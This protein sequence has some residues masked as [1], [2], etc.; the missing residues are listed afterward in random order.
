[1]LKF[2]GKSV[3]I[4]LL[5]FVF[6][7]IF[8][9]IPILQNLEMLNPIENVFD[10]F[11]MTDIVFSQLREPPPVD[12]NIVMVNFGEIDREGLALMIER[13]NEAQPL[14]I[15]IDAFY[16]SPKPEYPEGDSLLAH[17]LSQVKNLVM[18]S[19]LGQYNEKKDYYDTLETSH[20]MFIQQGKSAFANLTTAGKGNME[21]FLTSR[22]F[23]PV[24]KVKNQKHYAFAVELART[25]KPKA[26]ERFLKR[27]KG[28]ELINYRGNIGVE[29]GEDAVFFALD[30]G[31]VLD[32][33]A[34]LSFI[35]D[36]IVIIG[37]MGKVLGV[38]SFDDKF[39][40]PLNKNYVGKSTP[41]MYGVVVHANIV[42]MILNENYISE[43]PTWANF[44]LMFFITYFSVIL[45]SYLFH[46]VGY[47][48]DA[49][50][51]ILQL[52]IFLLI[53]YAGLKSFQWYNLKIGINTAII[54]VIIAGI[55]IEIYYGLIEKLLNAIISKRHKKQISN[56]TN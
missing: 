34:D 37:F 41:D 26:V 25:M 16:R 18:V 5:I 43:L 31:Q 17:H 55:A 40:T 11:D 13:L 30:I 47:W 24:A 19:G 52:I 46:R 36:K 50:T 48:Y 2:Y 32:P 39:Y 51:I 6:I 14:A 45:F 44:L 1:M 12:T 8:S 21:E 49:A 4:T 56:E 53:L 22:S 9:V 15:G 42:S 10:D 54:S 35:K 33:E 27:N 20:P 28:N 29:E 7:W 38:K 23:M 3:L